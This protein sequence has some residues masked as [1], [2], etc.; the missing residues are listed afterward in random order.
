MPSGITNILKDFTTFKESLPK[1]TYWIQRNH[2]L[3]A[4]EKDNVYQLSSANMTIPEKMK[5]HMNVAISVSATQHFVLI[6]R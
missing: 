5:Y 1:I 6:P 2:L 4:S 3:T